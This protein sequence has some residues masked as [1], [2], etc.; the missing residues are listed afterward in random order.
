MGTMTKV[1]VKALVATTLSVGLGVVAA[2]AKTESVDA[3][4]G[5]LK[6]TYEIVKK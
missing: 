2:I 4:V 5:V 3:I 6:G 1:A